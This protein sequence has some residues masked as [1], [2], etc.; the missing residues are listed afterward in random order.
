[1]DH[2]GEVFGVGVAVAAFVDEPDLGVDAFEST[3][4]EA[5]FD[6]GDVPG[7]YMD[8][9]DITIGALVTDHPNDTYMTVTV[10]FGVQNLVP[11]VVVPA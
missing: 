6:G 1:M 11:R 5:V 8:V 9:W 3:V 2:G 7:I 10:P 4:G